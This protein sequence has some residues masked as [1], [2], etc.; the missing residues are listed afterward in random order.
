MIAALFVDPAGIYASIP[1]VEI[2]DETRDARSYD[3][4]WP[5]VAHPPCERWG[6]YWAGQPGS[7]R[8]KA[9]GDDGG[10]F[11][12]ALAAVRRWGGVLEHPQA[13]GAFAAFGLTRPPEN[14]G[15][16]AA[17]WPEHDGW[18]CYVEQGAYGHQALKRTWLYAHGVDL[19]SLRWGRPA[20][21]FRSVE[22]MPS[23][24]YQRIATP[25]AFA[26]ALLSISRSARSGVVAA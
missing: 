16:V 3:G 9:K 18:S 22:N 24:G 1:G 7:P 12:A 13:S 4:P 6:R 19:P 23:A 21:V 11:A 8:R 5:V 17:D 20:G 14:G 15:W 26:E 10:C 2:W 25:L